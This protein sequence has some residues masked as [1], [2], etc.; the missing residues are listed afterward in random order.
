MIGLLVLAVQFAPFTETGSAL[1]H[2][3]IVSAAYDDG[4]Y[5]IRTGAAWLALVAWGLLLLWLLERHYPGEH[6][7]TVA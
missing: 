6:R 1:I 2:D 5:I 7:D 4:L 3:G